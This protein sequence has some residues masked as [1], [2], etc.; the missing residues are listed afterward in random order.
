[1]NV[2]GSRLTRVASMLSNM[3]VPQASLYPDYILFASDQSFKNRKERLRLI[4]KK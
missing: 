1:M 4:D 3:L 2:S